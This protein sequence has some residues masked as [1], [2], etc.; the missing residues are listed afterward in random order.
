MNTE[1]KTWKTRLDPFADAYAEMS[2]TVEDA[3]RQMT[4]AEL[5]ALLNATTLPTQFNCGWPTYR[6]APVV[7]E[8]VNRQQYDRSRAEAVTE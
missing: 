1:R 8:A 5:D 6:V 4:D 3:V 7:A 2:R